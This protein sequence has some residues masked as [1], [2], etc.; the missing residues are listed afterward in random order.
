[1]LASLACSMVEAILGREGGGG[2]GASNRNRAL[3]R[4]ARLIQTLYFKEG[5]RLLDR[6]CLFESGRLLDHLRYLQCYIFL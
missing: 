4:G 3:V 1:M 5:G 6:R 2:G